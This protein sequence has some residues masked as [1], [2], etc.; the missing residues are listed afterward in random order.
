MREQLASMFP[1]ALSHI[2]YIQG[3]LFNLT[4]GDT[5]LKEYTTSRATLP[6]NPLEV[7]VSVSS[8]INTHDTLELRK[9]TWKK[10]A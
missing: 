4:T 2:L 8:I 7:S 10:T 5:T 6:R 1:L 9:N 3:R